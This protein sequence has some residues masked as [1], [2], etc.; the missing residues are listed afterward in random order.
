MMKKDSDRPAEPNIMQQAN[1]SRS[2]LIT[3]ISFTSHHRGFSSQA[4]KHLRVALLLTFLTFL[5][6]SL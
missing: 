3:T 6:S 2:I 1:T 4:S 5:S